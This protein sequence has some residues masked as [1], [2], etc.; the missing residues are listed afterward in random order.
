MDELNATNASGSVTSRDDIVGFFD[1]HVGDIYSFLLRRCGEAQLA[2]DLTQETFVAATQQFTELGGL[3]PSA[4]LYQV[5]R[6]RLID[7]WRRE[8][9]RVRKVRLLAG[10]GEPP[11]ADPA[12]RVVSAQP[13]LDA[14][15]GMPSTQR[16]ALVLRYMDEYSVA[17]VGA[18]LG[19]STKATESLLARARKNLERNYRAQNDE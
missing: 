19:K 11:T 4:W 3:P 8:S 14:L 10:G 1:R 12:D 9:R 7:H 5:A 6:N 16:A 13:V 17:E 18:V 15:E 2:E